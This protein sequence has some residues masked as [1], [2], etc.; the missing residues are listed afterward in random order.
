MQYCNNLFE[1]ALSLGPVTIFVIDRES[2]LRPTQQ[3]FHAPKGK[4]RVVGFSMA[5]VFG[6]TTTVFVPVNYMQDYASLTVASRTIRQL[7]NKT[8]DKDQLYFLHNEFGRS[9]RLEPPGKKNAIKH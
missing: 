7:R 2:F 5:D 3:S 9:V 8:K 6:D 4:L 1:E